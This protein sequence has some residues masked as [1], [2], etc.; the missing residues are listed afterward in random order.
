MIFNQ[1]VQKFQWETIILCIYIVLLKI[2]NELLIYSCSKM[3]KGHQS[4]QES[5]EQNDVHI[6][7]CNI[8]YKPK[9]T[10]LLCLYTDDGNCVILRNVAMWM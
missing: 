10:Y 7:A 4:L 5:K 2:H 3:M 6:S 8:M 9:L 1:H